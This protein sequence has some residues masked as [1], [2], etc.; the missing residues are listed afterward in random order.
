[1]STKPPMDE[2][3]FN[4]PAVMDGYPMSKTEK[5]AVEMSLRHMNISQKPTLRVRLRN[6]WVHRKNEGDL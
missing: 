3:P 2:T 1:M 5:A 6:W 4:H